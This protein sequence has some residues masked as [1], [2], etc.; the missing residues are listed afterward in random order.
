LVSPPKRKTEY[1]W[2]RE[3]VEDRAVACRIYGRDEKCILVRNHERS[4]PLG[5]SKWII[6]I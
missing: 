1:E 5:R 6:L 2:D 4:R 3:K